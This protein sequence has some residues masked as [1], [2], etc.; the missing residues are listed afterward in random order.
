MKTK[1]LRIILKCINKN[2]KN[3]AQSEKAGN[4]VSEDKGGSSQEILKLEKNILMLENSKNST[5]NENF[6]LRNKLTQIQQKVQ[7]MEK[8]FAANNE[9]NEITTCDC[10]EEI[11]KLKRELKQLEKAKKSA[12]KACK[13]FKEEVGELEYRNE[14]FIANINSLNEENR[15]L[16]IGTGEIEKNP[17]KDNNGYQGGNESYGCSGA[18]AQVEDEIFQP[19]AKSSLGWEIGFDNKKDPDGNEFLPQLNERD[20]KIVKNCWKIQENYARN[21]WGIEEKYDQGSAEELYQDEHLG[22]FNEF[23]YQP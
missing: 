2:Y 10:D 7:D 9:N 13:T 18:E 14:T 12:E 4:E 22:D 8:E 17:W 21:C 11:G 16:R 15:S 23:F 3:I 20:T 19:I 6:N 1:I 5:E